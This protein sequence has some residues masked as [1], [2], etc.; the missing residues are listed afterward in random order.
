MDNPQEAIRS[1]KEKALAQKWTVERILRE[2]ATVDVIDPA[3]REQCAG[4][5]DRL[6]PS[7]MQVIH[8]EDPERNLKA[9]M[10]LLHLGVPEGTEGIL[11]CLRNPE[12]YVR[13]KALLGLSIL[14][15]LPV[16]KESKYWHPQPVPADR[17]AVLS[18]ISG[19]LDQPDSR[20]GNLA[21]TIARKLNIPEADDRVRSLW[22]HRSR[23]VRTDV[24][25]WMARHHEDPPDWKIPEKL[26]FGGR[27]NPHDDYWVLAALEKYCESP[28][29]PQAQKAADLLARYVRDHGARPDN[30]TANFVSRAVKAV[31]KT[32]YPR[33]RQM[34]ERVLRSNAADWRQ[35]AAL[36]RLAEL[37]GEAGIHRLGAALSKRWLRKDAAQ[38]LAKQVGGCRDPELRRSLMDAAWDESRPEVLRE[39]VSAL[40]AMGEKD[41]LPFLKGLS[42]RL[43]PHENMRV[44][45]L[46]NKITPQEAVQRLTRPGIIPLPGDDTLRKIEGKWEE[47]QSPIEIIVMLLRACRRLVWF[48]C[49]SGKVPVDYI[50]LMGD[51]LSMAREVFPTE[52]VS[53]Q[54][55]P[56]GEEPLIRFIHGRNAAAFR[57][58]NLGDWYDVESMIHGLNRALEED[59]R[60][61]RF[62]LIFTGDQSCLVTFGPET[63][64]RRAAEDL[65]LHFED[66]PRAAMKTGKAFEQQVRSILIKENPPSNAKDT[67]L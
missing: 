15:L 4:I 59:G 8:E 37:E 5:R 10:L 14:P 29:R 66:D 17:K 38:G 61:E 2:L 62:L 67:A 52:A 23:K 64:F 46:A 20:M 21:L 36:R 24:F 35:G 26:L 11:R 40:L 48:D 1:A 25:L 3:F 19:Y 41:T 63:A 12:E 44:H 22:K 30:W 53:Q 42:D 28:H 32:Q 60:E 45:W 6:V 58:R 33:E 47:H 39:L 34:L 27:H 57:V 16:P 31:A 50:P 18:A 65:L 9:G 54:A 56:N 13:E 51:L 7:L 49:E 55:D 43:G